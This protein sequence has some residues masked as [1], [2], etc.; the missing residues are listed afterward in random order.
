MRKRLGCLTN[1]GI[2]SAIITLVLVTGLG[3]IQGN[4]LFSPG[5]LNSKAGAPLGG[6][7]S[8][9]DIGNKCALCHPAPWEAIG[10]DTRCQ[11]CHLDIASQ[12]QDNSSLHGIFFNNNAHL[13]CRICH[14]EHGGRGSFQT[15]MKTIYFPHDSLGFSLKTHQGNICQDCHP[16]SVKN[17][18]LETCVFCHEQTDLKFT[19]EHTLAF[20]VN[21]LACH[22]GLE[23]YGKSFNHDDFPYKILGKHKEV[24]CAVCHPTARSKT[25]LRSTPQDCSA[26]HQKDNIHSDRIGISCGDCHTPDGWK[27]AKFD[28]NLA[29]FKLEGKHIDVTC[30][31][32]HVGG[33]YLGTAMECNACHSKDDEHKG[34]YGTNCGNC[35]T[36]LGWKPATFDH[37]LSAF[38][39]TGMHIGVPCTN[40]HINKIFKGT[41]TDCYNCHAK[42]DQHRG[43][44][45]TSCDACHT[46]SGWLPATFNHAL[47]NFP[48][49]GAHKNLVCESCHTKS[50]YKFVSSA[51]VSCHADP[52]WHAGSFGT[53]CSS[54]H[55][56]NNWSASYNGSH[57]SFG[58]VGGIN[59]GG[60]SCKTC[61]PENV[62]TYTCT[63]CHN[64]NNPG[65]GD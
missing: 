30:E 62:S 63:S 42:N 46:T 7:V 2:I 17:F 64:S 18:N 35:H 52:S 23:T 58:D 60:A 36:P 21:C 44:F 31:N 37:A 19:K 10:I 11:Q 29:N 22:D 33:K 65:G 40:C 26:C 49:T 61:H 14:P 3:L 53:N 55:T 27:P 15:V 6:Y 41:P 16:S 34:S 59:H 54:C 8:H 47:S 28:H 13:T 9:A 4:H 45:G 5:E 50:N 48:L 56:T 20:G 32:C 57:P 43:S 12:L 39:L 51:C 25:D 38:P 1:S 24:L